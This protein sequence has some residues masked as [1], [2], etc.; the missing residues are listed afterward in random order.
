MKLNKKITIFS[1][2]LV[3]VPL[4]ILT[5]L[6]NVI[7]SSEAKKALDDVTHERLVSL[8]EVKKNQIEDYFLTISNQ[9]LNLSHSKKIVTAMGDFSRSSQVYAIETQEMSR[10]R[11]TRSLKHYYDGDF[12]KRYQER[13][14]DLKTIQ[15]GQ[16]LSQ[17]NLNGL[18]LQNTFIAKNPAPLGEKDNLT[19]ANDGSQYSTYHKKYHPYFR[20]FL[21]RFGFYDIFLVDADGVVVYS[22]YKE[23]DYATSLKNGPYADSGLAR[24]FNAAINATDDNFYTIE[25]FTA[26]TPSYEDVAGFMATPIYENGTKIG[27]LIFQMPIE[28]INK[29]MTFDAGWV[30]AGLGASG[31]TYLVGPDMLARSESRFLI[32]DKASYITALKASG[33]VDD[34]T[35]KLIDTRGSTLGLKSIKTKGSKAAIAGEEGY[36]IFPNYRNVSVLSAYSP[37]DIAGLHWAILAEI[38]EDEAFAAAESLS[39]TLWT[40]GLLILAIIAVLAAFVSMKFSGLLTK[41]ILEISNFVTK[42]AKDLNLAARM[43]TDRQDEIGDTSRALNTLL[44]AFQGGMNEVTQAS[45]QVAAAAGQTSTVT[46]QTSQAI[47]EQQ[48]EAAQVATAMNEMVATVNEVA[49]NT[50]QTSDAADEAFNHVKTGTKTMQETIEIIHELVAITEKTGGVLTQLEQRSNDISSVVDVISSVAEQTNLLALNAAIEAARAGEHG[51]GFAVV[52]DEVRTLASRTQQSTGEI[53]QMIEQLQEGSKEAVQSMNLSQVQVDNAMKKADSAGETLNTIA[54]VV[55]NIN[56]MSAHIA[57][58]A[59]EQ[60]SVSEEINHNIVRINEMA[61]QTAEGANQ[62]SEASHDLTRL[63]TDLRTLVQRFQV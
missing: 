18:A 15:S 40:Y 47:Q 63:S 33:E 45:H 11:L 13:N 1:I 60:S 42:T 27:A 55:Q 41:A 32:Q 21:Q 53:T 52:A 17:L 35:V 24:A 16:L 50:T 23:L 25:D 56:D 30:K 4:L 58:A 59:E 61:D 29:V 3:V 38:N 2:L 51:R 20:D 26:Y 10:N 14:P 36:G 19:A 39:A 62:T 48:S 22:V 7:A 9:L 49:V 57:T 6:T 34:K 12:S 28:Q 37:I 54:T 31:E 43:E 8:M 44:E 46:T 5:V